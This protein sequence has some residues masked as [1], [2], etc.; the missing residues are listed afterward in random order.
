MAKSPGQAGRAPEGGVGFCQVPRPMPKK[1]PSNPANKRQSPRTIF[2]PPGFN[3]K[4][5]TFNEACAYARICRY[6]GYQR[7]ADGRWETFKDGGRHMV[8]FA[9]VLADLEAKQVTGAVQVKR[10]EKR[11]VGRPRK[12]KPEAVASAG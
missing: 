9:S 7:V 5:A 6:T 11:P 8:V 1:K 2:L 4:F 12:I 10:P 3:P